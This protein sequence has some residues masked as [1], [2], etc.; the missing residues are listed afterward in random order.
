MIADNGQMALLEAFVNLYNS[1]AQNWR[2]LSSKMVQ[3]IDDLE[4]NTIP[5]YLKGNLEN[6]DCVANTKFEKINVQQCRYGKASII[7]DLLFIYPTQISSYIQLIPIN[8]DGVIISGLKRNSIFVKNPESQMIISMNCD[9]NEYIQSAL[10]VCHEEKDYYD[11]LT[12]LTQKSIDSII[13]KCNFIYEN[14]TSMFPLLSGALLVQ[15]NHV[16]D[17]KIAV[18]GRPVYQK[19]P[20]LIYSA[21]E[22]VIKSMNEEYVFPKLTNV[23]KILSTRLSSDQIH[24]MMTNCWWYEFLNRHN[25]DDY[26]LWI[27]IIIQTLTFPLICWSCCATCCEKRRKNRKNPDYYVDREIKRRNYLENKRLL[28]HRKKQCPV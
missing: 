4:V 24:K 18:D 9:S 7:C 1:V 16:K 17:F 3:E 13:K 11:C 15:N 20:L 26:V 12:S 28:E 14:S 2:I 21:A 5:D 8:Y 23:T 6:L 22:I 25:W 10:P 19:L 27:I